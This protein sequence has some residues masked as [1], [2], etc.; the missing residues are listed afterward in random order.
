MRSTQPHPIGKDQEPIVQRAFVEQLITIELLGE[1]FQFKVNEG[2]QRAGQIADYLTAEVQ[3]VARQLPDHVLK[4]NKLAVVVSAALNITK[5]YIEL[6]SSHQKF[7]SDV[8][9][10]T[11][12]LDDMLNGP[13]E[14]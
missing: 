11:F 6:K 10:R 12:Q 13:S 9:H 1:K 14:L 2:K 7:V 5:Q 8:T 3:E 4:T